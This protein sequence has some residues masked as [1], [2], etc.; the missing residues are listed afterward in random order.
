MTFA[1]YRVSLKVKLTVIKSSPLC[2][3]TYQHICNIE[4][5]FSQNFKHPFTEQHEITSH[6]I[7]KRS[8]SIAIGL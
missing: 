2:N 5:L 7:T 3:Y 4:Y 1:E 6:T 8:L